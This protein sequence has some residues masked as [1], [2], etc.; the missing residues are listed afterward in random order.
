MAESVWAVRDELWKVFR[1]LL[2][3]REPQRTGRPRVDDRVAFNAVVYVLVAGIAGQHMPRE[4]ACRPATPHR[5]LKEGQL[6]G[7][8]RHLHAELVRRLN[9]AGR[10]DWSA[11]VI[12]GSP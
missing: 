2:P 8:W 3:G 12:D 11:S 4:L 10:I 7:L 6:A 9:A 5:R 1:T